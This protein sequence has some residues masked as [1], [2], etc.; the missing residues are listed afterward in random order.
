MTAGGDEEVSVVYDATDLRAIYRACKQCQRNLKWLALI[1]LF[2]GGFAYLDGTRGAA[3]FYQIL[4][5]LL[6][7]AAIAAG[8]YF[9]GPILQLRARRKNGWAQP[10]FVRLGMNGLSTRHPSQDSLFHWAAI[11]DVVVKGGRLFLFTTP[12][13][14]IILPRRSFESDARYNAWIG[15]ARQFWESARADDSAG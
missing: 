14:A 10:M 15:R 6:I 4:P 9:F 13:C 8:I 11:H 2:F 3:L 1:P 12:A 5:Y 7:A